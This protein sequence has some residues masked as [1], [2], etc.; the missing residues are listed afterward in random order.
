MKTTVMSSK[1]LPMSLSGFM[2]VQLVGKARSPLSQKTKVINVIRN[3]AQVS[4]EIVDS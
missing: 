2:R 4:L 3:V 1:A